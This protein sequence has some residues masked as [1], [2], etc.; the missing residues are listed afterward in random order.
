M[1]EISAI[2]DGALP[3]LAPEQ[4]KDAQAVAALIER[5]FGPGRYVKAAERLREHNHPLLDISHVAWFDD[6]LV[7]CVRMWPIRIGARP[8]VLLGPFAV[9][10]AW[11]SRGLGAAL[12]QRA[13][14]AAEAAGHGLILL[15]GDA[16][17]FAPHG[18][19]VVPPGRIVMPGPVDPA[20]VM[21][22]AFAADPQLTG[23]VVP[24]AP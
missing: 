16:P 8:A 23:E 15:V 10:E 19:Q 9:D 6:A 5:A 18:F 7:G 3:P 22:R 4:P 24:R 11:R 13:C 17:L 2:P 12:I 1:T 21:F 14:E 20:R